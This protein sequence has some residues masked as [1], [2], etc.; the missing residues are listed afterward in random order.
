MTTIGMCQTFILLHTIL[1]CQ[2]RKTPWEC[3]SN[4]LSCNKKYAN[5]AGFPAY[6]LISK[7]TRTFFVLFEQNRPEMLRP[8]LKC[9]KRF[10]FSW[11]NN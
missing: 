10:V 3:F 1:G 7:K 5:E 9:V 6:I 8:V 4:V 2:P 11:M